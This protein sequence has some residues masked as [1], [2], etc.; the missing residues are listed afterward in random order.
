M[1][2]YVSHS[3]EIGYL[4]QGSLCERQ[5]FRFKYFVPHLCPP[6]HLLHAPSAFWEEDELTNAV[7]RSRNS[8]VTLKRT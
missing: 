5:K 1:K 2:H 4:S 7:P 8:K 6:L 3:L